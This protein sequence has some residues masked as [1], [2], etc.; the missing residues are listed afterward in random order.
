MKTDSQLHRDVIEQLHWEPSI[1]EAE[2][3]TSVKD[4][5]VTLSGYVDSF[6]EKWAAVRAVERLSGVRAAVD[7]LEVKLPSAHVRTDVDIAHAVVSALTWDIQV[8]NAKIKSTVRDGWL[9]L[10]GEVEWEFQRRAAERAVRNITGVKG[11]S[12]LIAVKPEHVS[13]YDVSAKIKETLRRSAEFDADRITVEAHDGTVTLNGTVRSYAER[14]DAERAAWSAP[15]VTKVDDYI[16][17]TI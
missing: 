3:G 6:A 10:E 17:V 5:V 14:R 1:R 15:G 2:I 12:N 13:P 16:A 8:P 11:V 9:T 4:G 7:N